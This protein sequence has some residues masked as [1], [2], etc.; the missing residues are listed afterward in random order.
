MDDKTI[1]KGRRWLAEYLSSQGN[2][3]EESKRKLF[4]VVY[5]E[6]RNRMQ[7]REFYEIVARFV[8]TRRYASEKNR[9]F[10]YMMCSLTPSV[11]ETIGIERKQLCS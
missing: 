11:R 9:F 4:K 7:D 10:Y 6:Y 3:S 1:E 2:L 8:G 5:K